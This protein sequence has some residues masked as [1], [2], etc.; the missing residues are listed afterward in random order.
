MFVLDRAVS[1][2]AMISVYPLGD[3]LY[4]FAE[5]PFIHR[6]DPITLETT[7]RVRQSIKSTEDLVGVSFINVCC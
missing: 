6:I 4:A 7:G 2:N 1:D 3:E 5:S